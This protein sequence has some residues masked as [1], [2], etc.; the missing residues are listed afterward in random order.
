V[1]RQ[2]KDVCRYCALG[3]SDCADRLIAPCACYKKFEFNQAHIGCLEVSEQK[4]SK[5]ISNT[6]RHSSP[7]PWQKFIS[8][9]RVDK[10]SDGTT[11]QIFCEVLYPVPKHMQVCWVTMIMTNAVVIFFSE[12]QAGA[13]GRILLELCLGNRPSPLWEISPQLLRILHS[14]MH[15]LYVCGD[16]LHSTSQGLCTQFSKG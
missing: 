9:Q 2:R 15:L 8:E 12:L 13:E 14:H 10:V 7:W 16:I 4:I 11:K 3:K 5:I 6:P 1:P